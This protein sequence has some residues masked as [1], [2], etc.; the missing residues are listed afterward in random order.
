M[1]QAV[2][3]VTFIY[4]IFVIMLVLSGTLGGVVGEAVYYLAFMIPITI[5]FYSSKGLRYEREEM[6][7]VAEAPD[8]LLEVKRF[9]FKRL[10]PLVSP[11]VAVVFLISL[12]TSLLLSLL[13][14]STPTVEDRNIFLMILLHALVPAV[15]EEL[16]FRYIPMKLLLPYSKRW[17]I[18]YSAMCFALIH[19][20]FLQMPYAFAAGVIFMIIDVAM[21]S[22]WPSLIL[23]FIN[24]VASIIWIKYCSRMT[25]SVIFIS[26]MLI[27][28]IVSLVFVYK[29]R[30]VYKNMLRGVF[31]KGDAFAVTYAPVAL[32]LITCYLAS[33]NL[34]S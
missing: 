3:V 28:S 1:T 22:V 15:F 6:A 27:L 18:L 29:K 23:H 25:A 30:G 13:G 16:L 21:G 32:I 20:S 17:C 7:G 9:D 5:G 34:F 31:D 4:I 24:N 12:I 14:V 26:F 2:K 11:T 19:C 10:I 8:T 33:V